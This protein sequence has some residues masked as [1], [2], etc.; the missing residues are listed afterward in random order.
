[1][2]F[3]FTLVWF[4]GISIIVVYLIPNSFIYLQIVLFQTIQFS[5]NTVFVSTQLN[6]KTVLF[7]TIQFRIRTQFSSN[8]PID[9]TLSSATNPGQSGPGS[10]GNEGV[11]HIPQTPALLEPYYQIV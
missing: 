7:Q 11:L 8:Q 6:V 9:R 3:R 5:I 1:M 2:Q 10:D 4:Y